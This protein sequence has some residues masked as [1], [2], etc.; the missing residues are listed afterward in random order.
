MNKLIADTIEEIEQKHP[1][2]K[3]PSV[4]KDVVPSTPVDLMI[5]PGYKIDP[6]QGIIDATNPDKPKV[7]SDAI[8]LPTARVKDTDNDDSPKLRLQTWNHLKGEWER[9]PFLVTFGTISSTREIGQLNNGMVIAFNEDQKS[10]AAKFFHSLW[11]DN[12]RLAD[13][14]VIYRINNCGWTRDGF[15]YPFTTQRDEIEVNAPEGTTLEGI[16]RVIKTVPSGNID[17][18]KE[19]ITE[20]KDNPVLTLMLAGCLASPLVPLL[21]GL[22]DENIGIDLFGR[23][24]SGKTTLQTMAINLIY[25]LGDNLKT[26]WAK[27]REAGIWNTAKAVNNLVFMLDDSHRISEKLFGVPHDLIN[28]KEGQKSITTKDK[29]WAGKDA[30]EITYQGVILFNGEI[31]IHSVSPNDTAGVYGRIFMIDK[32]P[33]PESVGSVDVEQFKKESLNNAGHFAKPWIEYIAQMNPNDL[34][35]EIRKLDTLFERTDKGGLFGRLATKAQVLVYCVQKFNELFDMDL[36][37]ESMIELLTE[38]MNKQTENVEVTDKQMKV[39]LDVVLERSNGAS[40]TAQDCMFIDLENPHNTFDLYK[41]SDMDICYKKNEYII[42]KNGPL[43]EL[44]KKEGYSNYEA[45]KKQLVSA[46]Y[47]EDD[48]AKQIKYPRHGDQS[49]E[50]A[51]MYGFKFPYKKFKHLLP[52]DN[53]TTEE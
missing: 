44:L 25:G 29:G 14:P 31:S 35:N 48:K 39:V 20:Q 52:K 33:F 19:L 28:G 46:G 51:R 53:T 2:L 6:V 49:K 24:S 47:L 8:I 13:L 45:V 43:K 41:Y 16:E 1:E 9:N 32:P 7:I 5:P 37:I 15:F 30:S 22:L 42:V 36:D 21:K 23:T 3:I 11:K 26:T 17:R 27:A 34:D 18:A 10:G 40:W 50:D 4:F 12:N 38:S